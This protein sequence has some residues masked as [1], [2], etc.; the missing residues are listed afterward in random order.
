M[1]NKKNQLVIAKKYET[2]SDMSRKIAHEIKNPLTPIQLSSERLSKLIK[3]NQN[4]SEIKDCIETISR[5]V[6][7]IGHLVNE[8]SNFA[9]L[10]EPNFD[11]IEINSLL[12]QIIN[13]FNTYKNIKINTF[14]LKSEYFVNADVSQINR[15]FQT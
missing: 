11:K 7:E 12:T 1:L 8:F 4:N 5:Q 2:W 14:L 15:A 13:S 9:R 6:D 10:P 3:S